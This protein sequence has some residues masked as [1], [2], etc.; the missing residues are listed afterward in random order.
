M[1]QLAEAGFA[2]VGKCLSEKRGNRA[3]VLIKRQIRGCLTALGE[4]VCV[5]VWGVLAVQ[6]GRSEF[7]SP[8]HVKPDM[9]A[10]VRNSSALDMR[11]EVEPGES[12]DS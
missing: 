11:W 3:K 8:D 10:H 9:E 12:L 7:E 6:V 5:Y 4:G 1:P 2:L